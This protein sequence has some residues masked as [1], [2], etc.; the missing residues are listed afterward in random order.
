MKNLIFAL[1]ASF[2]FV[3]TAFGQSPYPSQTPSSAPRASVT[4]IASSTATPSAITIEQAKSLAANWQASP[5]QRVNWQVIYASYSP[6]YG[7]QPYPYPGTIAVVY[8]YCIEVETGKTVA[9]WTTIPS[10]Y[11]WR[12]LPQYIWWSSK[13]GFNPSA[14]YTLPIYVEV[15]KDALTILE[16]YLPYLS[17]LAVDGGAG[18]ELYNFARATYIVAGSKA[19]TAGGKVALRLYLEEQAIFAVTEASRHADNPAV[20]QGYKT[21]AVKFIGWSMM[22]GY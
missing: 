1:I 15:I 21:L 12:P 3:G 19:A 22:V 20:A 16:G 4:P 6:C 17:T 11:T 8:R 18:A 5:V 13:S 14:T 7:G 9:D 10:Y 2:V